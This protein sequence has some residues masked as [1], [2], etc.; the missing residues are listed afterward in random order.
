MLYSIL[1]CIICYTFS[2]I[3]I[4]IDIIIENYF[5]VISIIRVVHIIFIN[6]YVIIVS[7]LE[8]R[9]IYNCFLLKCLI[10]NSFIYLILKKSNILKFICEIVIFFSYILFLLPNIINFFLIYIIININI[11]IVIICIYNPIFN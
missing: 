8:Y 5:I 7:I 3:I 1:I 6:Y 4:R 11:S 9:F 2:I 10:S